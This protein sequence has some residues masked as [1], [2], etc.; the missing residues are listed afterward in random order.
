M[1]KIWLCGI[2]VSVMAVQ[3]SMVFASSMNAL[4]NEATYK[5]V[6]LL[7]DGHFRVTDESGK[8][9]TVNGYGEV[10]VT[11]EVAI[12]EGLVEAVIHDGKTNFIDKFTGRVLG[13]LPYE[14]SDVNTLGQFAYTAESGLMGLGQ[15]SDAYWI[16]QV[17]VESQVKILVDGA[18]REFQG[19]ALVD[20]NGYQ[21]NYLKLRDVASVMNGSA[22]QFEVSWD[23]A[24]NIEK[25]HSYT[26][27][28][29]EFQS[30][31]WGSQIYEINQS[32]T[33]IQGV[34]TDL[35]AIVLKDGNGS[36]YTY[37]KLRD[38]GQVLDFQITWNQRDQ[39]IEV[40]SDK[41]YTG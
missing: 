9:M 10:S 20:E 13:T 7:A 37:Y 27:N 21:T 1:K 14:T 35:D 12:E 25:G 26:P 30:T 16:S 38:L 28:G 36:G 22:S 24:I 31:F 8:S 17:A 11:S 6:Q 18:L 15:T 33:N 29:T 41:P 40:E 3:G 34:G 2:L 5:Q 4:F 23:G 19:Y 32:R 39:V